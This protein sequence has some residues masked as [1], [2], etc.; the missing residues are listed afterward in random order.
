[1]VGGDALVTRPAAA[2]HGRNGRTREGV[3]VP[4]CDATHT[5]QTGAIRA[6]AN[7]SASAARPE[8]A[9]HHPEACGLRRESST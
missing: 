3:R 5:T 8:I 9:F 2:G 7:G 4:D 6:P 1:M